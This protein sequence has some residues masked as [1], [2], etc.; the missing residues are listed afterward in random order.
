VSDGS[1]A[2][3]HSFLAR[4]QRVLVIQARWMWLRRAKVH[5]EVPGFG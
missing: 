5:G 1:L 4:S 2:V 3:P